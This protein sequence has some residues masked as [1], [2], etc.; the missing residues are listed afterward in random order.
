[1]HTN[2]TFLSKH[3]NF[4]LYLDDTSNF[5]E[6]SATVNSVAK[7]NA[8]LKVLAELETM[9]D[10]AEARHEKATSNSLPSNSKQ[11]HIQKSSNKFNPVGPAASKELAELEKMPDAKETS[12]EKAT[13]GSLSRSSKQSHSLKSTNKISS[14]DPLETMDNVDP[15][16]KS[17]L[18]HMENLKNAD[19]DSKAIASFPTDLYITK[20]A[21]PTSTK[22][23]TTEKTTTKTTSAVNT[24]PSHHELS[25]T[26]VAN[27]QTLVEKKETEKQALH[28]LK[29]SAI[30][31]KLERIKM[32]EEKLETL[33][34][35]EKSRKKY[36]ML[37][38]PTVSAAKKLS[39]SDAHTH[40][41]LQK[42]MEK[43]ASPL[44][45]TFFRNPEINEEPI[46]NFHKVK[47]SF[48][49][50]YP[51]LYYSSHISSVC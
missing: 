5:P 39:S 6:N 51:I 48:I 34:R 15:T 7:S 10:G 26:N 50:S 32:L 16:S 12:Q 21:T 1:M 33:R 23:S 27:T 30:R 37:K 38:N 17:K 20:S 22:T 8:A 18:Y 9:P 41:E 45:S 31:K 24:T 49:I 11:L 2:L 19:T 3:H 40:H 47:T 46:L 36:L 14:E 25:S 29:N 44:L 28:L 35:L 42:E 43:E 13:A 4:L